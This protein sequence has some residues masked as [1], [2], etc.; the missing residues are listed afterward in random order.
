MRWASWPRC[1][2]WT[3][4][5]SAGPSR[6]ARVQPPASRR[7]ARRRH[8]TAPPKP[9]RPAPQPPPGRPRM[10]PGWPSGP[11]DP[12]AQGA[13]S[14]AAAPPLAPESSANGR[15][16][17]PCTRV[18]RGHRSCAKSDKPLRVST[19]AVARTSREEKDRL[20]EQFVRLCEIE[21]PSR[22]ERK[23]VDAVAGELRGLGLKVEEDSSAA[24]TGSD[25]GNLIA[26]ID[27]PDDARTIMLCAHL[28]TVPL[29]GPVEVARENGLLTNKHEAIL[30]ADN[31]AAVAVILGVA[32]RLVTDG[33]PVGVELV[34]T[35][36]EELA[37]RG[38]KAFDRGMLRSQ[39]GFVFH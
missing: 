18:G 37:L 14:A 8:G 35:T 34:F 25:S 32:R 22:R 10:R 38:A 19:A 23:C 17:A 21:S 16:P 6:P 24:E 2:S 29:A 12:A 3:R 20:L 5:W 28:D 4:G 27:G 1:R 7:V 30:G 39:Y 33:S 9:R 26:R 36:C 11:R 13:S 15:P 31:K